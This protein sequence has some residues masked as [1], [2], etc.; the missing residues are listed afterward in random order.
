MGMTQ[1]LGDSSWYIPLFGWFACATSVLLFFA[2]LLTFLRIVRER[3]VG[4]FDSLP[5]IVSLLQCLLWMSYALVSKPGQMLLVSSGCGIILQSIWCFLFF[6]FSD[7]TGRVRLALHLTA[8]IVVWL[9]ATVLDLFWV[10]SLPLSP[11]KADETAQME[12]IGFL[13]SFV[14]VIML[15][16]PLGIVRLVIRTRSVEYMPFALSAMVCITCSFWIVFA[17]LTSNPWVFVPNLLGLALG[18]VQLLVY[19][20]YCRRGARDAEDGSS[21]STSSTL[22]KAADGLCATD[23]PSHNESPVDPRLAVRQLGA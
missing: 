18:L 8:V 23:G 20:V 5:Y 9:T 19:A 17:C 16:A 2:P 10:P 14:N 3:S 1:D 6:R 4:H 15:G 13:A 12:C 7:R 22:I 21:V 11:L